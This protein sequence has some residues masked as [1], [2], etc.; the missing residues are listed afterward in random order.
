MGSKPVPESSW[1]S[2]SEASELLG[3][4]PTTLRAWVDAG[5]V[6]AFLTPGGHRRF[7]ARELREFLRQRRAGPGS[8]SSPSSPDRALEGVRNILNTQALGKQPWYPRFSDVQTAWHRE[9]G[10]RLLTLLTDFIR[11]E[12][13]QDYILEEA[14]KVGRDYGLEYA[15][16]HCS[17]TDLTRAF[18]FF[19]RTVLAVAVDTNLRTDA[20]GARRLQRTHLFMDELLLATLQSFETSAASRRPETGAWSGPADIVER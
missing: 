9:K 6:R 1:L 4:H 11:D 2:L 14:R 5:K 20:Q 7:Q 18:L 19:R 17:I 8:T 16:A 10:R 15:L 13:D 3:V 12:K